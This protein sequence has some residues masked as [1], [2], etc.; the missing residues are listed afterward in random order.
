LRLRGHDYASPATYLITICTQNRECLF[1]NVVGGVVEPTIAGLMIE[2]WWH[3]LPRR[4]PGVETDALV[5]MPNHLHGV[6]F[7]GIDPN[8]D[9][10]PQL[11][12]I[13]YWFKSITV[14]DYGIGAKHFEL[15]LYDSRLWQKRY[16]DSIL[17]DDRSLKN[18]RAY[19]E[20]NT[21]AWSDDEENPGRDAQS[22]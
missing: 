9:Q 17:R 7:V 10:V 4:F 11:G 5:V 3:F 13:M 2:S 20:P 15:K 22:P 12:E 14:H 8:V 18:A 16:H 21:S 19:I 6:L 1:G